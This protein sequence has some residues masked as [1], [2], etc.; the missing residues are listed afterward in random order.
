MKKVLFVASAFVC[1]VALWVAC[2]KETNLPV[3]EV[4][5]APVTTTVEERGGA[6]C[7][8]TVAIGGAANFALCGNNAPYPFGENC[9]T[10][11]GTNYGKYVIETNST[12]LTMLSATFAMKN[13]NSTAKTV[14]FNIPGTICSARTP[15]TFAANETKTLAIQR[16]NST[17][18]AVVESPC[19]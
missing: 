10:C 8:L 19:E 1:T 4:K 6:P 12:T 13:Q 3:G 15:I 18:C 17:C 11:S 16:I 9:A 14:S 2:T 5:N 7:S